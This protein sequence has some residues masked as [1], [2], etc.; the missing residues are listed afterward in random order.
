M[1]WKCVN[2]KDETI[3]VENAYKEI[4][5]FDEN[6]NAIGYKKADSS[7]KT[8]ESYRIIPMSPRLF[9]MLIKL[10]ES[11]KE[12]A[13]RN[14]IKWSDEEYVFLNENGGPYVSERLTNKIPAF[15]KKYKLGKVTLYGLR[16]SFATLCSERGVPDVVLKELMGHSDSSTTKKYYIHVTLTR[17]REEINKI[18]G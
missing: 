14:N 2:F 3:C 1:K 5:I 6:F 7:L 12:K 9:K 17:K 11:K 10:K 8:K 15:I 16:H 4:Q 13:K 18:W